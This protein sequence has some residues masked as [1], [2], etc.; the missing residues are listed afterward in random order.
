MLREFFFP[1]NPF[2]DDCFCPSTLMQRA[3]EKELMTELPHGGQVSF[4]AL[5]LD[6]CFAARWFFKVKNHK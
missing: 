5:I 2:S 3:T 4:L 6:F 1:F